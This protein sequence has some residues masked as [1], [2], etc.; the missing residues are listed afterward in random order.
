MCC[1][2]EGMALMEEDDG[3]D[4]IIWATSGRKREGQGRAFWW[5]GEFYRTLFG[6]HGVHFYN[7]K[8]LCL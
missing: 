7:S 4:W 6:T 1:W 5:G 3:F 8:I 2:E